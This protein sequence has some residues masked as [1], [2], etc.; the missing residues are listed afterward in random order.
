MTDQS[1]RSPS[2]AFLVVA[3][4]LSAWSGWVRAWGG[5]INPLDAEVGPEEDWCCYAMCGGSLAQQG[6]D[7]RLRVHPMGPLGLGYA[8]CEL[9]VTDR[10]SSTSSAHTVHFAYDGAAGTW[11]QAGTELRGIPCAWGDSPEFP[12]ATIGS[13][14]N[15]LAHQSS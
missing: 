11:K 6:F 9:L 13:W 3:E 12:L 2:Q 14:M 15:I 10:L 1:Q 8:S 7:C 4:M 5:Q